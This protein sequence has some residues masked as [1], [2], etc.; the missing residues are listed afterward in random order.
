M[1]ELPEVEVTRRGI[2]PFIRNQLIESFVIRRDDLRW[3]IPK[4]ELQQ[5]IG[6][7][8]GKVSRRGKYLCLVTD[9]GSLII[10]LGMSGHLRIVDSA[11]AV[12]KHDHVDIIFKN[13][14]ILR[15]TDP[16]RF[17]ALLWTKED[18]QRHP[19][20]QHL[21]VE[22]LSTKF[23]ADYLQQQL[24]HKT[25]A[26]KSAIMDQRIVVGIGNIYA[27]EALFMAGISPLISAKTLSLAHLKRL[28][29]AIQQ[30]LRKAILHGGS[31]LKD[32]FNSDGKPGYFSQQFKVYGRA[33]LPCY[34]CSVALQL[35]RINQRSTV[36]CERCQC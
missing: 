8:L 15:L 10:H 7:T 27:S 9:A 19:L 29:N 5:V 22:P 36:Y 18:P 24:A 6:H 13:G 16:R 34:Q 30:I 11:V 33:G 26:I 4:A 25:L 28:V 35:I 21:G 14:C 17:A 3:P 32:F 2:Q 12:D 23:I 20:L 1:P 31:T